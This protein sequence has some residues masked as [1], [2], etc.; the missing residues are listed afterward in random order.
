MPQPSKTRVVLA[1]VLLRAVACRHHR[2][3]ARSHDPDTRATDW[4]TAIS[5][6]CASTHD[7]L[8]VA[9][10]SSLPPHPLRPRLHAAWLLIAAG[11]CSCPPTIADHDR[12]PDCA[13]RVTSCFARERQATSAHHRLPSVHCYC[14]G[15]IASLPTAANAAS[16]TAS[17][18]PAPCSRPPRTA[19]TPAPSAHRPRTVCRQ[20]SAAR[21][22]L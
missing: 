6:A 7:R 18:A 12:V 16:I 8:R 20:R 22:W 1:T 10:Y 11:V 17:S 19:W 14:A 9:M 5:A 4:S 3:A 13:R 21:R 2:T 15:R